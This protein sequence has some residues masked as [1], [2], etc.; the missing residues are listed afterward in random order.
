L[1]FI[2]WGELWTLVAW[3]LPACRHPILHAAPLAIDASILLVPI[4]A[5]VGTLNEQFKIVCGGGRGECAQH[6]HQSQHVYQKSV[7]RKD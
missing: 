1:R 4:S 7:A 5:T 3:D 2:L 6:K